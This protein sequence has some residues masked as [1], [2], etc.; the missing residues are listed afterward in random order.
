MSSRKSPRNSIN[1]TL[2]STMCGSFAKFEASDDPEKFMSQFD[3]RFKDLP[4]DEKKDKL[5][6]YLSKTVIKE[7]GEKANLAYYD[8]ASCIV[9]VYVPKYMDHVQKLELARY[10]D[11]KLNNEREL[12]LFSSI[13]ICRNDSVW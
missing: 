9:K 11:R 13:R 10:T 7:L 5:L 6:N 2:N 1:S 3:D 12:E 8:L 4:L